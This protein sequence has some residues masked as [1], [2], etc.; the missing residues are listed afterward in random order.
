M[1]RNEFILDEMTPLERSAAMAQGKSYDRLPCRP[2]LGE[3]PTRLTGVTVMQYLNSPQIIAAAQIA[4]F[5]TYGQD[6]IGVGPDQFG[7]A[8]ALGAKMVY[9]ADNIPQIGEPYIK[10][11]EEIGKIRMIN[12][13]KD[14][15]FPLY[16]EALDILGEKIGDLVK[17]G[18]G[19][20]GPFTAAALLRGTANF[21]RDT[22]K[23]PEAVHQLLELTTANIMEYI[24]VCWKRGF[25]CS[26]GESLGTTT[27]ISPRQFRDF[28]LPYLSKI[29]SWFQEKTGK[30]YSLH[31]CGKTKKIW[32][33]M[34]D[35]GAASISLD[36]MEDLG[37]AKRMIGHLV[38]LSGNVDPIDVMLHGDRADILQAARECIAKAGDNPKGYVLGTS[39]RVPLQTKTENII[40]L[41]DGVRIYGRMR[42]EEGLR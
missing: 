42:P 34:A 15:R 5:K 29:G 30:G 7:L 9:I 35:T 3:Q 31:I 11:V 1:K 26:I 22:V 20:G 28:V 14:G 25:T 39:C 4:A 8:E 40:A 37:E 21:L 24:E 17:V 16:L 36:H 12:P 23:N 27:V 41:M 6:G 10:K 19:I 2:S 13:L 38:S 18:T 33:H 32:H